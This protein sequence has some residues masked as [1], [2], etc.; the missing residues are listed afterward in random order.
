MYGEV[1]TA[2]YLELCLGVG[3]S[4]PT[5]WEVKNN[6]WIRYQNW[7]I[8]WTS[9]V[10]PSKNIHVQNACG[11]LSSG[12]APL[13]SW[14]TKSLIDKVWVKYIQINSTNNLNPWTEGNGISNQLIEVLSLFA[15]FYNKTYQ[16][17]LKRFLVQKSEDLHN[18]MMG[19]EPIPIW[20]NEGYH[21][22]MNWV[23]GWPSNIFNQH[24]ENGT[25]L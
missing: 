17:L 16:M 10:S 14:K 19:L 1:E 25:F 8:G 24:S 6:V 15:T 5:G 3:C 22:E 13:K 9:Y 7:N 12:R 18:W 4:M 23:W 20:S 21:V 11:D 2:G